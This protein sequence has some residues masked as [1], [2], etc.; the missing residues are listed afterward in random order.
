MK[1]AI[2]DERHLCESAKRLVWW[3][4]RRIRFCH[5]GN[6]TYEEVWRLVLGTAG[7]HRQMT[8]S[9]AGHQYHALLECSNHARGR[10]LPILHGYATATA[11]RDLS[12]LPAG[13]SV[14]SPDSHAG[15]RNSFTTFWWCCAKIHALILTLKLCREATRGCPDSP[16]HITSK[17]REKACTEKSAGRRV[18]SI[19]KE[20]PY[21]RAGLRA[22]LACRRLAH[23]RAN[24]DSSRPKLQACSI[25]SDDA[26][27]VYDKQNTA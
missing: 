1:I 17:G 9:A 26:V 21:T 27:C 2:P 11:S 18:E 24:D 12:A 19:G 15:T 20:R 13:S 23:P 10:V 16:Q 4:A 3:K 14:E 6:A 25:K 8:G 22:V 7:K 5:L